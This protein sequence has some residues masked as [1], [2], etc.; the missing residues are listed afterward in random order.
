M[1]FPKL[2]IPS[3]PSMYSVF[4]TWKRSSV[5]FPNHSHFSSLANLPSNF[6]F[7]GP[8]NKHLPI[9]FLHCL[10][11]IFSIFLSL[12]V[13][14]ISSISLSSVSLGITLTSSKAST[15]TQETL[16]CLYGFGSKP[17]SAWNFLS[18]ASF[19]SLNFYLKGHILKRSPSVL[20][21][22]GYPV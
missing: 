5:A 21:R 9:V 6:T 16:S 18:T 1:M 14:V 13:C 8:L 4:I 15:A 11:W 22:L 10:F 2:T 20:D 19:S 12:L 17:S 3:P 7:L